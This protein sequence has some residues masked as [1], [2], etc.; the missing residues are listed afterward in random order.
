MHTYKRNHRIPVF[1]AQNSRRIA[2]F[3]LSILTL[4]LLLFGHSIAF[5][6]PVGSASAP[7]PLS[8]PTGAPELPG[9]PPTK[10][11]KVGVA[12]SAPFVV[13]DKN[14]LD[15]IAVDVWESAALRAGIR[16][17]LVQAPSVAEGINQVASGQLDMLIG[18]IS[19]TAQRAQRAAFTQPFYHATLSILALPTEYSFWD[20]MGAIFSKN[21]FVGVGVLLLVLFG[22]GTLFWLAEFRHNES[23]FPKHPIR[24]IGNGVWLALVTLTT[25]GYGD[26]APVTI[27]GRTLAGVWMLFAMIGASSLTASI[28]TTLTLSHLDR[29]QVDSVDELR[30]R[31]VA[32]VSGSTGET[33]ARR[34]G[35]VLVQAANIDEAIAKL[36]AH[37]ADAIVFDRPALQYRLRTSI[38]NK[39]LLSE[40][41]YEPQGYGFVLPLGSPLEHRLNIALLELEERGEID[42]ISKQWLGD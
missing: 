32:V 31:K 2:C 9:A 25:V 22:V 16:Y 8:A 42:R 20:R 6:Q 12:G 36:T 28:A 40:S 21:F 24:G 29:G 4:S 23:Q 26:R 30:R 37:E 15:G 33:F 14:T 1:H 17:T 27:A 35:A 38:D 3:F 10:E 7:A 5:A 41:S 11:L 39:M 34:H 18:P 13:R 19:I